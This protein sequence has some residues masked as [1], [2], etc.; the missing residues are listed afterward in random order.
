VLRDDEGWENHG[1]RQ[2]FFAR[3][4]SRDPGQPSARIQTGATG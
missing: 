4:R 2:R 3:A 1:G